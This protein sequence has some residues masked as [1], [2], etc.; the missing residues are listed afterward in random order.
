MSLTEFV[1]S[2]FSTNA[3]KHLI[4]YG[5]SFNP[6]HDGHTQCVSFASQFFPVIVIPDNNPFKNQGPLEYRETSI[7]D[8]ENKLVKANIKNF[9]IYTDFLNSNKPT[10]TSL[11]VS[12]LQKD[13]PELK[14]HLLVGHDNFMQIHRWKNAGQLLNTLNGLYIVSR[15]GTKEEQE[16]Q[17]K[18][19]LNINTELELKFSNNHQ[20]E[21]ISSTLIREKI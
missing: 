14:I 19:L 21:H 7:K 5:G 15:L 8:I 11:W 10:P 17:S 9:S 6:W 1:K 3:N 20:F 18:V 12:Q 16:Q 13:F 2:N 4:F